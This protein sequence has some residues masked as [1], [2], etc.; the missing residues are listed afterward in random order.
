MLR[1]WH[2]IGSNRQGRVGINYKTH[3]STLSPLLLNENIEDIVANYRS[4]IY[5]VNDSKL[6]VTGSSEWKHMTAI[7]AE[8]IIKV[9]ASIAS[10]YT[11]Y[12]FNKNGVIRTGHWSF[13]GQGDVTKLVTKEFLQVSKTEEINEITCGGYFTIALADI[14]PTTTSKICKNWCRARL[15]CDDI[16]RVIHA[17]HSTNKV[18]FMGDS[19]EF[20]NQPY[21]NNTLL[22]IAAFNDKE[23][24][25]TA[26][27]SRRSF[28]LSAKGNIYSFDPY[29]TGEIKLIWSSTRNRVSDYFRNDY[30]PT[31]I[32][33]KIT[34]TCVQA[35]ASHI[36]CID[37][38]NSV[39]SFGDNSHG[40]C[41]HPSEKYNY[42]HPKAIQYLE[43]C[44]IVQ[45]KTGY[46]HSYVRTD[47]GIH[48][49][50]GS[51]KCCE[52][53]LENNGDKKMFKPFRIN[54]K[55]VELTGCS[56]ILNV[57]VGYFCT[58]IKCV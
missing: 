23:I 4:T 44:R 34:V 9:A 45:I 15:I 46:F 57:V 17:F 38:K 18:Y 37:N 31:P 7:P 52:C 36:L 8:N 24:I 14:V 55:V 27:C 25:Q 32:N 16:I 10:P 11:S 42:R 51:N 54:E 12:W 1:S 20:D 28:F 58:F 22:N 56:R 5:V 35:G 47:A 2:V 30:V 43:K 33:T 40:Q 13:E 29:W 48:F 26:S 39:Y 53:S 49:L 50:F 3:I 41:G 21:A 19:S 6:V